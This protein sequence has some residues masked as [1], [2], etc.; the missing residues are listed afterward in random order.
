MNATPSRPITRLDH[1]ARRQLIASEAIDALSPVIE[2]F[3][4]RVTDDIAGLIE[5][6]DDP[7]ARQFLPDRRELD[8][9]PHELADPI[10]DAPH[11]PVRGI[12]HRYPDRVLLKPTH[13]CQVYCRFC[14]RR[15]KVGHGDE[16]LSEAELD[17]ALAY[18]AARPEIFEVILT[19]GDPLVL[20]DRRL[21]R[22]LDGLEAIGHVGVV[23]LHTRVVTVDPGRITPMLVTTLRRRFATWVALHV[24]HVSE[25]TEAATAALDRLVDGGIPLVSQTVLL[26]GVNDS[27]AA[28]SDLM[29]GLVRRR[30]KPYYLHH[31]DFAEGTSHF[32]TSI[33]AGKALVDQ[34]RGHMSGLAQPTY[35]LDIPGGHGKSPIEADWV[36]RSDA[37]LYRVRDWKGGTHTYR[38]PASPER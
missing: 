38:D 26:N 36:E 4:L 16:N 37:D 29:R 25:L 35:V 34:L 14:F 18:I 6:A 24:N 1:L 7:I 17:A 13:L 28:L 32:R 23:R 11:T 3:Q 20:S 22:I 2:R 8:I 9:Q 31:L 30:V 12:T 5:T 10:G 21:G 19:G 27:A 15:E 33:A